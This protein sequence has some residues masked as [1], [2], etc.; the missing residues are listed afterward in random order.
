MITRYETKCETK[1]DVARLSLARDRGAAK[2]YLD[3][4]SH[5]LAKVADLCDDTSINEAIDIIECLRRRI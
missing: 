2:A 4:A 3:V 1:A 5:A